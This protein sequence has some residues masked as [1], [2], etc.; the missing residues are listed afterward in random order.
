MDVAVTVIGGPVAIDPDV[1]A[2]LDVAERLAGETRY[3]TGVAV[4]ERLRST[5]RV[6]VERVW[7]ATGTN[8]PD[9]ITAGPVLAD[10]G[11]ALVLVDGAGHGHDGETAAWMG[12]F[13][14]RTADGRVIGGPHAVTDD[15]V[16]AFGLRLT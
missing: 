7:A 10:L 11:H 2:D 16:T 5:G 9:A 8:W 13:A 4:V 1:V 14:D 12:R 3:G 15:A 6:D